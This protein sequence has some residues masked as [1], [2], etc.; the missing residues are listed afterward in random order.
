MPFGMIFLG[1]FFFP[2]VGGCFFPD[3]FFLNIY[4]LELSVIHSLKYISIHAKVHCPCIL[5]NILPCNHSHGVT[6]YT[7]DRTGTSVMLHCVVAI[8]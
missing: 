3:F 8:T 7:A 6:I 2:G 1:F 5:K 4:I